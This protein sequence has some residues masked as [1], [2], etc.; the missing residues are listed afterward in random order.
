MRQGPGIETPLLGG[1]TRWESGRAYAVDIRNIAT[2]E[3]ET[4]LEVPPTFASTITF[5]PDGTKLTTSQGDIHV[6]DIATGRELARI[7]P[8]PRAV[9]GVA[10]T[11]DGE[12]L[13]VSHADATALVWDWGQFPVTEEKQP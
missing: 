13:V 12:R 2:G 4:T 3:L 11:P 1:G 9:W 10:F 7:A 8:D 6:F 5:S